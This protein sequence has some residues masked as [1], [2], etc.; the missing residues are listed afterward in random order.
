MLFKFHILSLHLAAIFLLFGFANHFVFA[1]DDVA[2]AFRKG[3]ATSRPPKPNILIMMA[4][5]MGIGDTS[6]YLDVRLSPASSPVKKTLRTPHLKRFAKSAIVFTDGYAPASMCSATRYS[7]LTGRFAHRSYLKYQGW[8]PH[9]PNTPMIQRGIIT[10]PEMLQSNGYRTAGIGKYHVG[11]AF[12][13]G[14]GE[15]AEDFF[16]RDVDFTKPILDGPTH[17]GFDE[18][19]GV[20]GNTEDPLDTEPRILIR[21]DR[22]TFTDRSQMKLIGMKNREGRILS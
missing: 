1:V 2:S 15:P 14:D 8:L 16:F 5:D 9:G 13:N 3:D 18:Y 21:N 11:M 4:D 19:Y 12:D 17:H 22:F 10:L 6:V 20:A 7:L